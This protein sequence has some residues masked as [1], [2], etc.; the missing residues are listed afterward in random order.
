[1]Q[2][3]QQGQPPLLQ[4][5]SSRNENNS[6]NIGSIEGSSPLEI[7]AKQEEE[8]S[9]S[10]E[11]FHCFNIFSKDK[12]MQQQDAAVLKT[13]NKRLRVYE[14]WQ[15]KEQF[16]MGGRLMAGPN[17]KACIGTV[18]LIAIP[19][20]VF[21]GFV[22]PYLSKHVHTVIMA[23]S[24]ILPFFSL[25]FLLVTACTDPGVI[26]R[27][28]PD[29]EYL[30]GQKPRSKDVWV[31]GQRVVVRYN[32]TCHFYQPPRAHHCSVND[33]CIERFDHHCPWVGTT[34]GRRN[35]RTFLLFVYVTAVTCLYVFGCCLAQMFLR[36]REVAK[37]LQGSG[38]SYTSIWLRSLAKVPAAL[39]LMGF[40]FL[41][42]W[43]IGGLSAFHGYLVITNQTT[44]ENF[45]Y[46]HD[47]NR[48]N[49]Y[50]RGV[51]YNCWE[52]WCAPRPRRHLNY[53]AYLDELPRGPP[54]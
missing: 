32:D 6:N 7:Q 10:F 13:L 37:E 31:N 28:E 8:G 39:T 43:F 20:G 45:R 29:A 42:F 1:M 27:Q 34:I 19:S 49:P 25:L 51:L 16:F 23:F 22:A 40:S 47:A 17:W 12:G 33:N 30:T 9:K 26:P 4:Q 2:H 35:Y 48:P 14:Q 36:H 38:L 46:N 15:G 54:I 5:A 44:Y 18:S 3:P 50:S 11:A 41:F 24:C 53:R 21:L 52:V